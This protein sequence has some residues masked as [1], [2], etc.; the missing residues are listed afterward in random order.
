MRRS[1]ESWVYFIANKRRS[2]VKIGIS[3]DPQARLHHLQAGNHQPLKIELLLR[4]ESRTDAGRYEDALHQQ[5]ARH[6][7]HREWFSYA[8][9]IKAFVQ[10]WNEGDAPKVITPEHS[11][12]QAVGRYGE[13]LN[14]AEF[15]TI[16]RA[17]A[18]E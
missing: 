15:L 4:F 6:W 9:A 8:P 7:Q 2:H 12:N 16:L 3:T 5:F 11:C 10:S 17:S 14:K 1:R 13:G 18:A